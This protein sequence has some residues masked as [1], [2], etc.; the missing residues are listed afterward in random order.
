MGKPSRES[1]L[2]TLLMDGKYEEFNARAAEEPP[3][4]EGVDLRGVD[5]RPADLS[6]ANL[7]QA[8]LR[9]ADLRGLD[10]FR[11]DLEGASMK[12]AKVS[13]VCFPLNLDA[14]EIALSLA[15][16]TRLRSRR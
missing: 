7:R 11:A 6:R 5:L 3:D 14:A 8:Y 15:H 12:E 9:F 10:L 16:G 1:E 13:G 2:R 4:L